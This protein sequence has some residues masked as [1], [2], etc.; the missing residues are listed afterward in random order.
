MIDVHCHL[1]PGIDD[2]PETMAQSLAM[3][4]CGVA[5]GIRQCVVT[6]HIQ[7]GCYDNDV[8]TIQPVYQAFKEQLEHEGIPLQVGMAAEVHIGAELPA[9]IT[10]Q[11]IP[12]LGTWGN[13]RAILLEFPHDHIPVGSDTLVKWLLARDIQPVI[14]HPERNKAIVCQPD[15]IVPFVELGCLLQ[16][17]AGSVTGVFGLGIQRCALS[18]I[19]Q[20]LATLLASDAHNLEKKPTEHDPG[21]GIPDAVDRRRAS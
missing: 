4:R 12:Y 6:P 20:G 2:G 17:T 18:F 11:K 19:E 8:H 13:K 5:H 21:R 16:F 1:L 15:K 3:A 7:P 9:M 14:A 10:H